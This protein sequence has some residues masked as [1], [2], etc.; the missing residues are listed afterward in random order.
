MD[1]SVRPQP[2]NTAVDPLPA[3]A[4]AAIRTEDHVVWDEP[5]AVDV[6]RLEL[7]FVVVSWLM[8]ILATL[9][10]FA[11][12]T[13][14]VSLIS[15]SSITGETNTELG[16][17]M[18]LAAMSTFIGFVSV[19]VWR[20]TNVDHDR[21][22]NSLGV[23]ALHVV[24]ALVLFLVEITVYGISGNNASSI[25]QGPWTDEL[26][27]AFTTLERSAGAAILACLL[28]IGMVPALGDRPVGTQ[29]E[30]TPQ[31]RQL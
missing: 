15:Q 6:G 28:A 1:D 22:V 20:L 14:V 10:I 13:A 12:S 21:V 3:S 17:L 11:A 2:S 25:L 4:I 16:I 19:M 7:G 27:S 23:A 9:V 24:V 18:L 30:A 31:D 29:T 8:C 26:G 5:D